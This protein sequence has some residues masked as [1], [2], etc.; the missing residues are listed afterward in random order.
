LLVD[1]EVDLAGAARRADAHAVDLDHHRA[2]PGL[3]GAQ[4]RDG[5]TTSQRI[6]LWNAAIRTTP[7]ARLVAA[8]TTRPASTRSASTRSAW[9]ASASPTAVGASRRAF[10]RDPRAKGGSQRRVLGPTPTG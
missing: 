5:S 7:V 9:A 6:A 2:H 10:D 4:H 1:H 8:A 3:L